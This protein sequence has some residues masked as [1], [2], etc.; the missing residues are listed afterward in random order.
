MNER[1][2][3]AVISTDG[4]LAERL[5]CTLESHQWVQGVY[6]DLRSSAGKQLVVMVDRPPAGVRA[7]IPRNF[8]GHPVIIEDVE[9]SFHQAIVAA[10]IEP[11]RS[12]EP[13]DHIAS[14]RRAVS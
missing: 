6:V 12:A 4:E 10:P 9:G 11:A 13:S 3:P 1:P 5:M 14:S 2:Q 7:L 8:E